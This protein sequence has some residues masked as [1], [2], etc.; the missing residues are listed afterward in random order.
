MVFKAKP[1][2]PDLKTEGQSTAMTFIGKGSETRGGVQ[3]SGNLRVDG[4]I[5]GSVC[6]EGDLEVSIGGLIEGENVSARNIVVHGTVRSTLTTAGM[7]RI[8][9]QADV[10]G[11]VTAQALDIESGARFIGYSHTG[12]PG[13]ELHIVDNQ[14]AMEQ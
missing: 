8:H 5:L 6:S 2:K 9:R 14:A 12:K 11:D 3:V 13:A 7:L 10:Q 1:N 4:T